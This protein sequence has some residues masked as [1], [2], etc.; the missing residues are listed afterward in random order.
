MRVEQVLEGSSSSS[1]SITQRITAYDAKPCRKM[2]L[3]LIFQTLNQT[4]EAVVVARAKATAL[5]VQ[6][7]PETAHISIITLV[8]ALIMTNQ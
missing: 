5:M 3:I 2:I 6:S 1:S 4:H 7:E 8:T